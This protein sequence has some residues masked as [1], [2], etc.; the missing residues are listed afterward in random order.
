MKQL[1][2]LVKIQYLE[3][4]REPGVV[5]WALFFPVIL[6]W[7]LGLAFSEKTKE[8]HTIAWVQSPST[9]QFVANMAAPLQSEK[10]Q[11]SQGEGNRQGQTRHV[12]MVNTKTGDVAFHFVPVSAADA[13]LMIKRGSAAIILKAVHDSLRFCFDP[14][15]AEGKL[16]YLQLVAQQ[17]IGEAAQHQTEADKF[18]QPLRQR[19]MRY[20]D[21]LVPGLLAM[22][23][24]FGSMWGVSYSLVEKRS[25]KLLRRMVATPMH[26]GAFLFSF[27]FSRISLSLIEML[28]LLFF[29]WWYFGIVVTGSTW[30]LL[31][32]V[33]AGNIAFFGIAV[34]FSSRAVKTQV[35]N[36]IINAVTM[37]MMICSGIFFSYHNF[38]EWM[39]NIIRQLPLTQLADSVRSVFNE[40]AGFAQVQ[41]S[42][43][44]LIGTGAVTFFVGKRMYRWY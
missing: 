33:L 43:L 6:A 26:K 41:F 44:L 42:L 32:L 4:F 25:K 24:M 28:F 40:G 31:A 23:I 38:P 22:N 10:G 16:V 14:K 8:E 29:A 36:G 18:V 19:G 21:F 13:D 9:N 2:Q 15:S 17:K 11:Q 30:A 27:F 3:F 34:L 20:I 12:N 39:V 7:G 5:F 35:A 37:P 1:F